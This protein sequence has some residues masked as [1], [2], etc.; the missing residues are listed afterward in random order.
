MYIIN[1]IQHGSAIKIPELFPQLFLSLPFILAIMVYLSA[2]ILAKRR[3]KSW[4]LYRFFL[5][6][7]GVSCALAAVSGPIAART[8]QDFSAHMLGHL[9]LG[10]LAPL[11][12]VLA[13]PMTLILRSLNVLQARRITR[14][15][16]SNLIRYISDPI[17]AS[18]LNV[19]GLWVLYTTNLYQSMH[20]NTLLHLVV[21]MHIFVAG[22][23]FTAAFI[24]L[25]PQPHRPSYL[26]R[27]IV[28]FLGIAGHGILS[29]YIYANPTVGVPVAQAKTG[30]L[31]MYYGGDAIDLILITDRKSVV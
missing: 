16:R 20:N 11:L 22:Y 12:M 9:L 21:H 2:V 28:L 29:K 4:R 19:G 7:V 8:H 14:I 5:W 6:I 1:H 3:K 13:A 25:D 30:G 17:V 31:L 18:F 23:L 15:L 24:S 10:M 26:Y 27:S